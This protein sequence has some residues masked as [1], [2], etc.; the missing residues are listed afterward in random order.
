MSNSRPKPLYPW[1]ECDNTDIEAYLAACKRRGPRYLGQSA[2]GEIQIL[3]ASREEARAALHIIRERAFHKRLEQGDEPAIAAALAR[4]D[5]K[6]GPVFKDR[7]M[8]IFRDLCRFPS[9]FIGTYECHSWGE[10]A[11][12]PCGVCIVP[13]APNG[14]MVLS[15]GFHH[16]VRARTLE[17]PRGGL[18]PTE[19]SPL[20]TDGEPQ[21]LPLQS[22]TDE[23]G[24]E[25]GYEIAYGTDSDTI[26][27]LGP[28]DV[29]T[30]LASQQLLLYMVRAVHVGPPKAEITEA[31]YGAVELSRNDLLHCLDRKYYEYP[32]D[33]PRF[34]GTRVR[35]RGSFE[36]VALQRMMYRGL[37]V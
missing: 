26:R 11:T 24:E 10:D 9:G 22:I 28:I 35:M 12:L 32:G 6:I 27:Y 31:I 36:S 21:Q 33:H 25:V 5:N 16:A 17:F 34:A 3:A 8:Q 4:E 2:Q 15:D 18:H 13:V 14:K 7:F 30:G 19:R 29:D 37:I 20:N 1:N 23:V